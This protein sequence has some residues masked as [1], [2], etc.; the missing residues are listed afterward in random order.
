MLMLKTIF[1]ATYI[2]RTVLECE[3][4]SFEIAQHPLQTTDFMV[5]IISGYLYTFL[6]ESAVNQT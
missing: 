4:L 6:N 3:S 5:L 1:F 2:F